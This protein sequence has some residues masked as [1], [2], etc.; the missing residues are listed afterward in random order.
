MS[1]KSSVRHL[2]RLYSHHCFIS[3]HNKDDSIVR[4][5]MAMLNQTQPLLT[6]P[7]LAV[8]HEKSYISGVRDFHLLLILPLCAY[9]FTATFYFIIEKSGRFEKYRIHEPEELRKRNKVTL[10][11][12]FRS[13]ISQQIIQTVFAL[14]LDY[15]LS[16][17]QPA[18]IPPIAPSNAQQLVYLRSNLRKVSAAIGLDSRR[19]GSRLDHSI[20]SIDGIQFAGSEM[21]LANF[22]FWIGIPAVQFTGAIIIADF[23][24]YLWHRIFH[25]NKFLYSKS[26]LKK[27]VP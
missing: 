3:L 17:S 24:Q 25:E 1:T 23:W 4:F 11:E 13:I 9:W 14:T 21:L 8:S 16:S 19:I 10:R 20:S 5:I 7:V 2:K 27:V 22:I 26:S 15:L 12:V 6:E 18:G